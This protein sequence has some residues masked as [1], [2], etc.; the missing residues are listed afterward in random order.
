MPEFWI[1]L[2]EKIKDAKVALLILVGAGIFLVLGGLVTLS[3][4]YTLSGIKSRRWATGSTVPQDGPLPRR[5]SG[6]MPMSRSGQ[7]GGAAVVTA[8]QSR[9]LCWV[10]RS[11]G[12]A[13]RPGGQRRY[14]LPD[15][16]CFR[17]RQNRI[18]SVPNL[19]YACA[20]GMSW[21]ALDS[22]GD[23]TRNYGTIAQ[24]VLW[25]QCLRH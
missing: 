20:S 10:Q 14:P 18:L 15:D 1:T 19:E 2:F 9:G 4:T 3:H 23:L 17:Y 16:R 25:V 7:G 21:L 8:P 13:H 24:R 5:S 11:K 22:K 6:S 12:K